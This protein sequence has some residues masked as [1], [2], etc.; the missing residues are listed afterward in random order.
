MSMI[1]EV[2]FRQFSGHN[3]PQYL[4]RRIR[5]AVVQAGVGTK[6]M[7]MAGPSDAIRSSTFVKP[8]LK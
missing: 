1:I 4:S 5:M 2:D 8:A 3:T 7:T 6:C